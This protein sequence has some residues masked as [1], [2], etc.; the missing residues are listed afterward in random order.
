MAHMNP[1]GKFCCRLVAAFPG[2]FGSLWTAGWLLLGL[3]GAVRAQSSLPAPPSVGYPSPVAPSDVDLVEGLLAARRDYQISLEKLRRYYLSNN[4]PVRAR[5]AE[6]ELLQFHRILKQPF[7]LDLD[8]PPPTLQALY[9]VPEAN[10]LYRQAMD[11]KSRFGWGTDSIDNQRRAEMLFQ[12]I[13]T[14]Y[15]QSDKI[16]DAAF[17]LGEIYEGK[18]Y[19]QYPRA[20]AYYERCFQWNPNTQFDA[21]LRAARLYDQQL[22]EH[23][24]AVELYREVISHETD[25]RQIQEAKK[26]LANLTGSR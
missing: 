5:W 22:N 21:R 18:A 3:A 8:V 13:L 25:Q 10:E 9:N 19:K 6:E 7:R 4:D 16:D 15:P 14:N 24:R 2:S 23:S 26:R 11:Y 17:Q 20:A 12:Q 1:R